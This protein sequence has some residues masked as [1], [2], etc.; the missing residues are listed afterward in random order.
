MT[1]KK[2]L[3]PYKTLQLIF[4]DIYSV[5]AVLMLS[6]FRCSLRQIVKVFLTPDTSVLILIPDPSSHTLHPTFPPIHPLLYCP[7]L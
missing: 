1:E 7:A 2:A 6:H 3:F 4:D 5:I